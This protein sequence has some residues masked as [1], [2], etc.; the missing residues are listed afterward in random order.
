MEAAVCERLL[1]IVTAS[2][3]RKFQ[4]NFEPLVQTILWCWHN[5]LKRRCK[6]RKRNRDRR[7]HN[8]TRKKKR[9]ASPAQPLR[10]ECDGR[11]EGIRER[12]VQRHA[13]HRRVSSPFVTSEH[14][15][16]TRTLGVLKE[17]ARRRQF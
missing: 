17:H 16:R 6:R 5:Q 11:R 3:K 15:R 1:N 4:S 12:N 2:D 9:V 7:V 14:K 8:R 10:P 13:A